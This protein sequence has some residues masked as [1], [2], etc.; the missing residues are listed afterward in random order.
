MKKVEGV[1]G[2]ATYVGNHAV[3]I[4]FD[5][6]LI[7]TLGIKKS[8]FVPEKVL[9]RNLPA[10][11]DSLIVYNLKVD[12][13]FDPYDTFYLS[14]LLKQNGSIYGFITEFGC[15]V[16]ISIYVIKGSSL[17]ADALKSLVEQKAF[18]ETVSENSTQKVDLNYRLVSIEKESITI[19]GVEFMLKMK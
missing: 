19:S 9:I 14:E 12:N 13:F 8:I 6:T 7:D 1:T 11:N 4:W 17:T 18:E 16:N 5:P 15:P 10:E 2:V 3:K